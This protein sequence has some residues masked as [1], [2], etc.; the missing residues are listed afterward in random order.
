MSG[1]GRQD[2][3]SA[4]A[5][6]TQRA[7]ESGW[8]LGQGYDAGTTLIKVV[9]ARAPLVTPVVGASRIARFVG[10]TIAFTSGDNYGF[11]TTIHAMTSGATTEI[12]L[13][14]GLPDSALQ[15]DTVAIYDD[16]QAASA[17]LSNTQTPGPYTTTPLAANG[18][19]TSST[20]SLAG[21]A[22][23]TGSVIADQAGQ[24]KIQQTQ[25][26]THWD[27]QSVWSIT[28]NAGM[29]LSAEIVLPTGRLVFTNTTS[30]A[31]S[32]FRLYSYLR[33]VS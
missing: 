5:R 32:L 11:S 12:T 21:Y 18:V 19:F 30:S 2:L 14:E 31:Q 10:A 6:H 16:S 9:L 29:G 22:R 23:I 28:A 24:V 13:A 7:L 26:G 15:G 1:L 17:Q 8:A 3:T 25:D 33:A 27:V 20:F 4:L